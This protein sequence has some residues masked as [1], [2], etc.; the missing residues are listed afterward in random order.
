[1]PKRIIAGTVGVIALVSC[2]FASVHAILAIEDAHSTDVSAL[3]WWGIAAELLM[4]SMA[5]GALV[6]G[7]RF[8][9]FA[10]TGRNR[11][12][13]GRWLRPMLLGCGLFFPVFVASLAV[14]LNW[15]YRM[16]HGNQDQ[17][18]LV[19]LRISLFLGVA[20]AVI[21][22]GVLLRRARSRNDRIESR[23][24]LK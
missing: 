2:F 3:P 4:C 24:L 15:A 21:G 11:G 10:L 12:V 7:F 19:A 5:L 23:Q 1:M 8:L 6:I 22:S 14:G 18:A 20:A 9:D 17:N 16:S 13:G